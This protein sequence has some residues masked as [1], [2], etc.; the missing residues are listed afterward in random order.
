VI[1]PATQLDLPF[2][3]KLGETYTSEAEHHGAFTL[4][5]DRAF[6]EAA[7]AIS[8]PDSCLLVAVRGTTPVGFLYATIS[9]FLWS[10]T[11][12]AVDQLLYI[13]PGSRG[14]SGAVGLIRAY[15]RWAADKGVSH[16]RLSIASG[17][18]EDRTC[19]LY[20]RL[21]YIKI[22]VTY[23]KEVSHGE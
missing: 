8:D 6:R 23:Q 11:P 14:G 1:R 9:Y 17:I 21:G 22:G 5:W 16:V 7:A 18:T 3:A 20:E 4:N 2:I 13:S 15:E 19:R 10:D 12:L